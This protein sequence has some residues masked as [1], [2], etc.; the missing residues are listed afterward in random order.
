MNSLI[1]K[2]LVFLGLWL[3]TSLVGN[4][5]LDGIR[6]GIAGCLTSLAVLGVVTATMR[7]P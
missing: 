6:V 7:F 4:I 5:W 3:I 2:A 1:I